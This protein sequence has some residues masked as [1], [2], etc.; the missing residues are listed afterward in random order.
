MDGAHLVERSPRDQRERA[1]W[2]GRLP[3]AATWPRASCFLLHQRPWVGVV[4]TNGQKAGKTQGV[5]QPVTCVRPALLKLSSWWLL[6]PMSV[7]GP[8]VPTWALSECCYVP[9]LA[10]LS[11]LPAHFLLRPALGSACYMLPIQRRKQA[12]REVKEFA[13][14]STASRWGEQAPGHLAPRPKRCTCAPGPRKPAG[15]GNCGSGAGPRSAQ[16]WEGFMKRALRM[17]R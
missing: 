7:P 5:A 12:C 4:G 9:G 8:T 1:E 13:P 10:R 16:Q 17:G 6:F 3:P 14:E 11:L 15:Q 2:A